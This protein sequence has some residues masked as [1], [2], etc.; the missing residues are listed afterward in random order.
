MPY[1]KPN[2]YS[3][4]KQEMLDAANIGHTSLADQLSCGA[5]AC[6]INAQNDDPPPV[7]K[8]SSIISPTCGSSSMNYGTAT[9]SYKLNAAPGTEG[10][11]SISI[12]LDPY[13]NDIKITAGSSYPVDQ[14]AELCKELYT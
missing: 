4:N 3:V 13:T 11:E 2:L 5:S 9:P 6:M 7:C 12:E 1:T 8:P 14:L 10:D